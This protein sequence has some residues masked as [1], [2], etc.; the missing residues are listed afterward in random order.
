MATALA[1]RGRL[2]VVAILLVFSAPWPSTA[3]AAS[4]DDAASEDDLV[5]WTAEGSP[6]GA[7]S[8]AIPLIAPPGRGG[9]E[10]R[11]TLSY[12]SLGGPSVFGLGWSI[13]LPR[14][15]YATKFG[16]ATNVATIPFELDGQVLIE[17]PG[18]TD[19]RE[20]RTARE[21]FRRIRFYASAN[22]WEVTQ[23]DG[24]KLLFGADVTSR[25]GSSTPAR[26]W[27]L[28][29]IVDPHGNALRISY[30]K[31]PGE[32][33]PDGPEYDLRPYRLDYT[34]HSADGGVT[35]TAVGTTRSVEFSYV[36]LPV[37]Q[38]RHEFRTLQGEKTTIA[39]RISSITMKHGSEIVRTY[40]FGFDPT[41]NGVHTLLTS[42]QL[43]GTG[44]SSYPAW[45]FDYQQEIRS[46]GVQEATLPDLPEN[47]K[48]SE[49]TDQGGGTYAFLRD[50]DRDG[51]LD[52]VNQANVSLG[53]GQGF[54]A[55]VPWFA[56]SASYGPGSCSL[57]QTQRFYSLL[58]IDGFV[59]GPILRTRHSCLLLDT[60][61][62]SYPDLISAQGSCSSTGCQS[63]S[64][65]VYPGGPEGVSTSGLG[66]S[67]P[68]PEDADTGSGLHPQHYEQQGLTN[69]V[70]LRAFFMDMNGDGR[71]DRVVS[72]RS[73]TNR[74]FRVYLNTGS[75]WGP[76]N[77]WT[78]PST[79]G[80]ATEYVY[81]DSLQVLIPPLTG[82]GP[83][84]L[85]ADLID[86]NGDSLPDRVT[87]DGSIFV[88]W[89]QGTG[90]AATALPLANSSG[91]AA[92]LRVFA[93]DGV[94]ADLVDVNGDGLPDRVESTGGSSLRV[95]L[96]SGNGF[97]P[98]SVNWPI[99]SGTVIS[100]VTT[101]SSAAIALLDVDADGLKER[102]VRPGGAGSEWIAYGMGLSHRPYV[103]TSAITPLGAE[104]AFEYA[105]SLQQRDAFDGENLDQFNSPQAGD[106]GV[107][108]PGIGFLAEPVPVLAET[109]T[110]DGPCATASWSSTARYAYR[111]ILYDYG[112]GILGREPRGAG[113]RQVTTYR[114]PA[115]PDRAIRR[116]FY[117]QGDGSAGR[118]SLVQ[119]LRPDG[120][121]LESIQRYW[122]V[123]DGAQVVGSVPGSLVAR[124]ETETAT[125]AS[126]AAPAV[127]ATTNKSFAYGEYNVVREE[128]VS[129]A[130]DGPSNLIT[131]IQAVSNSTAWI[132]GLPRSRKVEEEAVIGG[133]RTLLSDTRSLYDGLGE[134]VAPTKGDL[135]EIRRIQHRIGAPTGAVWISE[136][137]GYDGS[138]G[139]LIWL[140][141]GRGNRTYLCWD[142]MASFG[143]GE[144]CPQ[145]IY[146]DSSR[147][148]VTGTRNA[149]GHVTI[150]EW[151][152]GHGVEIRTTDA[153]GIRTRR[154]LDGLGRLGEVWT[155]DRSQANEVLRIAKTYPADL[156]GPTRILSVRRYVDAQA[157]LLEETFLDA[158]G[159]ARRVVTPGDN[160]RRIGVQA[161]Y[162]FRGAVRARSTPYFCIL[163]DPECTKPPATAETSYA[164]DSLGRLSGEIAPHPELGTI[165]RSI[166][167][168]DQSSA[169]RRVIVRPGQGTRREQLDWAGRPIEIQE[170]LG[171]GLATTTYS[172]WQ[173][174]L[175]R[176]IRDPDQI[177]TTITYDTLGQQIEYEDADTGLQRF[178]YDA[179]G[180]LEKH[181]NARA[182]EILYGYDEL[183]RIRSITR[184]DRAS[185]TFS[186]DTWIADS[187]PGKLL[188]VTT[189]STSYAYAYDERGRL[190]TRTQATDGVQLQFSFGYDLLDRVQSVSTPA[191]SFATLRYA[192]DGPV[193][194]SVCR[195]S[196]TCSSGVLDLYVTSITYDQFLQPVAIEGENGAVRLTQARDP[197]TGILTDVGFATNQTNRLLLQYQDFDGEGRPEEMADLLDGSQRQRYGY[198]DL[199]RLREYAIGG[200][201]LGQLFGQTDAGNL[202]RSLSASASDN[203]TYFSGTHRI[204]TARD[205]T[206]Y[207]Y[208]AD[209]NVRMRGA[210]TLTHA[211]DGTLTS[212]DLNPGS[213]SFLYDHE[214]QRVAKHG[215]RDLIYSPDRLI[216][217][218]ANAKV[219][220]LRI[221]V[222]G[223]LYASTTISADFT[224]PG[225]C[226]AIPG[227]VAPVE[228]GDWFPLLGV[229]FV[230]F[231]LRY[232]R[233]VTLSVSWARA[234]G[235]VVVAICFLSATAMPRPGLAMPRTDAG[236]YVMGTLY[237]ATDHL[238]S[239]RAAYHKSS[240]ADTLG[241]RTYHPF[242]SP[243]LSMSGHKIDDRYTG[244]YFDEE[245]GLYY[246]NARYYDPIAGRFLEPDPIVADPYFSQTVNP[247]SYA[248]NDPINWTDPSGMLSLSQIWGGIGD[249]FG[250]ALQG[251]SSLFGGS[252]QFQTI[253]TIVSLEIQIERGD[254]DLRAE[255]LGAASSQVLAGPLALGPAPSQAQDTVVNCPGCHF[256]TPY[257]PYRS[258]PSFTEAPILWAGGYAAYSLPIAG[259]GLVAAETGALAEAS[260]LGPLAAGGVLS[261]ARNRA[262]E[263]SVATSLRVSA[264]L[265]AGREL[266]I[267]A[268]AR[269]VEIAY[270]FGETFDPSG[271]PSPPPS[272]P[273]AG[274][275]YQQLG[276]AAGHIA[277]YGPEA[278]VF[279]QQKSR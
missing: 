186:W 67:N 95:W 177:E 235:R 34:L 99:Q 176:T 21:S 184:P 205:G 268:G 245:T 8:I 64:W 202:R 179:S 162:T 157:S 15:G 89:N 247:Y 259:A 191:N 227:L 254:G 212:V 142:G 265:K 51:I 152:G 147:T 246:F 209:G 264:G 112:T 75:G 2:I 109:T 175:L 153:A 28:D 132:V 187:H 105:S 251:L 226:A 146:A 133:N 181:I 60:N 275:R 272:L 85:V 116:E 180:N 269:G 220:T 71:A 244:Q 163:G 31:P 10:P 39:H 169:R 165:E 231:A 204:Q 50:M 80:I 139:N 156:R 35:A 144:P 57:S 76:V 159:R 107:L 63:V 54:G 135:T 249:F 43:L 46:L 38:Y 20:F 40:A 233:R 248:L 206:S 19:Y 229:L 260:V 198:D 189:G 12:N 29:R 266:G 110:C 66:W 87:K 83:T 23:P 52:R 47:L 161:E 168:G 218:D 232:G 271:I 49:L 13:D 155:S 166:T 149:K 100:G 120:V 48:R 213:V 252:A 42:V 73:R 262:I 215:V 214:G 77:I 111:G 174:G 277:N 9:V 243:A 59:G 98:A 16:I 263:F 240:L 7:A 170:S 11:L 103:L 74:R 164:Y 230:V 68:E 171:A 5:R 261:V 33:T 222:A 62:D 199:G 192:Y 201:A 126:A 255:P 210:R 238:G 138:Y 270:G 41:Q 69:V 211:A 195:T 130:D 273:H 190:E 225:G 236:S 137:F 241:R 22:R 96:N 250:S 92:G 217:Y 207:L 55:P 81:G 257:N 93:S 119:H 167:H 219:A 90:F 121:V 253:T 143:S 221:H 197:A 237:Y 185:S 258:T 208:D 194:E 173:D 128:I 106:E 117:E 26:Q 30:Q 134:G 276:R 84:Y 267:I 118:L 36:Q 17:G 125:V 114:T 172:Y 6:S 25:R 123:E 127:Q 56:P 65:N 278:W 113:F 108:D 224:A 37:H 82:Q 124:V 122:A 3:R 101:D 178:Q 79:T 14:I 27:A 216:E 136:K 58:K 196:G 188:G 32:L 131:T 104:M 154:L 193:L 18:G 160:G 182:Q 158:M 45:E 279:L 183:D 44:G 223:R 129:S 91:F 256:G 203:Q 274:S 228:P 61:G 97:A 148:F 86:M 94:T 150:H 140:E 239:V 145:T 242:G 78:N 234:A 72:N 1:L 102:V 88:N 115:D 24:T 151:D 141:N 70:G 4:G 53:N 200:A